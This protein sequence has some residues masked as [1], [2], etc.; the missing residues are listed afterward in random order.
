MDQAR[1]PWKPTAEELAMILAEMQP[2]IRAFAKRDRER[3]ED[4]SAGGPH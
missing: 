2:I 1:K 3:L 4:G